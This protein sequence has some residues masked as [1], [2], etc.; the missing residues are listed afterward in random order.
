VFRAPGV[1]ML[2]GRPD[3]ALLWDIRVDPLAGC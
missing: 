2:Q 3:V 1:D